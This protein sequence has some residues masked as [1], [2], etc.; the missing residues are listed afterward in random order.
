MKK[1]TNNGL[2]GKISIILNLA[3]L[4]SFILTM[5]FLLKTDKINV[6]L[7]K[8]EPSYIE[9]TN[10]IHEAEQP[11]HRIE[12]NIDYY[13]TKLDSLK[14]IETP[15]N[16][17]DAKALKDEI[18]RIASELETYHKEK[19]DLDSTI[20]QQKAD[21][22]ILSADYENLKNVTDNKK[23]TYD[24]FCL[25]TLILLVI[26]IATFSIWNYKNSQ[27]LH[28]AAKW[29]KD[30][31]KP[32]WAWLGWIIPVYNLIKPYSVFHEIWEETDY[33]LRD[34]SIL[35]KD[36]DADNEFT[37]ELWWGCLLIALILCPYLIHATFF[38]SGAMFWKFNHTAVV[39]F[40]IVMWVLYLLLEY[41]NIKRFMTLNNILVENENKFE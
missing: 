15:K 9:G 16:K 34:K 11:Y 2:W 21:Y 7:T 35:A 24:I 5:V 29:M 6:E 40:A 37:L 36:K 18:S 28:V 33:V 1:I 3:I 31:H 22:E 25:I 14:A 12:V 23:S 19:S 13:S 17:K 20:A 30:G 39:I 4:V 26:K 41:L 10:A 38:T 32:F 27:N 8:L